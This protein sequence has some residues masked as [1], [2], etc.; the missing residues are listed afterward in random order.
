MWLGVDGQ[1]HANFFM[2]LADRKEGD[3]IPWKATF[4]AGKGYKA[5]PG[6][7]IM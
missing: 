3:D 4:V 6:G 1:A 5:F 7:L 2:S